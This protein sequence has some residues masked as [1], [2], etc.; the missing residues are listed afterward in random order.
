MFSEKISEAFAMLAGS[1]DDAGEPRAER[2]ERMKREFLAAQQR[3]RARAPEATARPDHTDDVPPL[4]GPAD[5]T[6]TGVA[7]AR[8]LTSQG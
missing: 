4:A 2:L 1:V 5:E 6:L 8:P 7:A 3:R